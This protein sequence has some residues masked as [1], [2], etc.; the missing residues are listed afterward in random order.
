MSPDKIIKRLERKIERL[1]SQ[2]DS[3]YNRLHRRYRYH[4]E[5]SEEHREV[6][7]ELKK[8]LRRIKGRKPPAPKVV[9]WKRVVKKKVV[10]CQGCRK[11][12]RLLNR[13]IVGKYESVADMV[14]YSLSFANVMAEE[15]GLS[16]SEFITL[17][18]AYMSEY[19]LR[20]D[21]G[22]VAGIG[23]VKT[24][25]T[26][27]SLVDKGYLSISDISATEGK[28][29]SYHYFITALGTEKVES[30]CNRVS[31]RHVKIL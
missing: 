19:I 31:K 30:I 29:V 1:R 12:Q 3:T 5:K 27:Q 7:R 25:R 23:N 24:V 2:R 13:P 10:K 6:I 26:L 8:E 28:R 4:R 9:K 15:K 16:N 18:Y 14:K 21:V 17:C 20:S 22:R 11:Y